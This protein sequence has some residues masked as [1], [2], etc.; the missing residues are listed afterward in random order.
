[1]KVV[2]KLEDLALYA[3]KPFGAPLE[4]TGPDKEHGASPIFQ[5]ATEEQDV[6]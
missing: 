5:F 6:E 4:G 1:V 3:A 2:L